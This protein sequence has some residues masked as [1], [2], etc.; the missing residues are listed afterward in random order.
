M[1]QRHAQ[2]MRRKEKKL[3]TTNV[4][5]AFLPIQIFKCYQMASYLHIEL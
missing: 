2:C 1:A 5:I 4:I 3:I